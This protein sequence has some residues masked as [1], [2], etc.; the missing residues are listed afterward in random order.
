[1]T[2]ASKLPVGIR[3][4]SSLLL[5]YPPGAMWKPALHIRLPKPATLYIDDLLLM[6]WSSKFVTLW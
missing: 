1:M 6:E 4:Y 3:V 5:G 2:N